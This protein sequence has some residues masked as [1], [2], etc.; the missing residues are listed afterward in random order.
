[1]TT[2]LEKISSLNE[3]VLQGKAL[4]AFDTYYHDDV[5]LHDELPLAAS[6]NVGLPNVK[7]LKIDL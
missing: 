2:L 5:C 3:L 1:M 4:E 6:V 7:L